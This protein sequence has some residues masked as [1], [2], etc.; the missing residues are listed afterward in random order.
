MGIQTF[1]E[2]LFDAWQTRKGLL[3]LDAQ[4][5]TVLKAQ[6]PVLHTAILTMRQEGVQITGQ[7]LMDAAGVVEAFLAQVFAIEADV[8]KQQLDSQNLHPIIHFKKHFVLKEAKRLLRRSA[9]LPDFKHLDAWLK[10]QLPKDASGDLEWHVATFAGHCLSEP[11]VHEKAI[12]QLIAWCAHGLETPEAK[13]QVATWVS[14]QTPQILQKDH[15]VESHM[16]DGVHSAT[17]KR[18]HRR[19]GFDLQDSGFSPRASLD[20]AHYC[21]YCH[22]KGT[23]FCRSGFPEKPKDKASP[24]K[25]NEAGL[26]LTGCPLDQKISEMH[27]LKALGHS[28]APLAIVMVD[29]PMCPAT[30]HRIC[31]DCMKSCIYQKQTPVNTPEVESRVLKDVLDLPWGVEVYDLLTK[32]NPLRAQQYLPE[33]P[34][35]KR[36]LVMG[37]GPAGFTLMHHLSM[38][39]IDVVGMDGMPLSAMPVS[40]S[41]PIKNKSVLYGALSERKPLGFGGVAEYG[42]TTR[43]DKNHLHLLYLTLMRRSSVH[44]IGSV[45]FGGTLHVEDVWR[46]GFDHL[47]LATGAGLPNALDIPGSLAPGMR[48]ASDFLM[49]LHLSDATHVEGQSLLDVSLPGLVI[50]GGL[51]AVDAATELQAYYLKQIESFVDR[52]EGLLSAFSE[53]ALLASFPDAQ[54]VRVEQWLEHG[55]ELKAAR[56]QS[57]SVFDPAPLLKKWGGV[58][59]VYRKAMQASPAYRLN[60]EELQHALDQ[61]IQWMDEASPLRIQTDAKGHVAALVVEHRGEQCVLPAKSILVATGLRLNVAYEFEHRGT[62]DRADTFAYQ[63]FDDAGV[64]WDGGQKHHCKDP[65]SPWSSYP[66]QK[67]SLLGDLHPMFQGSVV[68]AMASAKRIYPRIVE[69]LKSQALP[70][71]QV[72]QD[73]WLAQI[74][75]L[76]HSYVKANVHLFDQWHALVVQSSLAVHH[77]KLGHLFRL[78]VGK[79]G[80]GVTLSPTRIDHDAGTLTFVF[81]ASKHLHLKELLVGDALGVMGPSGIA[82]KPPKQTTHHL[83]ITDQVMWPLVLAQVRL[84]VPLG[85]TV[86]V[87][88]HTSEPTDPI[89][90]LLQ[91]AGAHVHQVVGQSFIKTEAWANAWQGE[92]CQSVSL[93]VTPDHLAKHRCLYGK[94]MPWLSHDAHWDVAAWGPFQCLL[95]G[96]CAQCLQWQIDPKTAKR[97]KAVYS[98]SW[99]YQS[100]DMIDLEHL[101]SRQYVGQVEKVLEALE[102]SLDR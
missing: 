24:L 19:D 48:S 56:E 70:S 53:E 88:L 58:K 23:D 32:W 41:R 35:N 20:H 78:D 66:E 1:D 64:P 14:F 67:V 38:A 98:C 15:L 5:L 74:K 63:V 13:A 26:M 87:I 72:I 47:A 65:L 45:R 55:R 71:H 39:G 51:T 79:I 81:D 62:F 57:K 22:D 99:P 44:M 25:E 76:G 31:N 96:V 49:A 34:S 84:L 94:A 27:A 46:L 50:G 2:A 43:W 61:G 101:Q 3:A 73:D 60:H 82:F 59:I 91:E 54:R 83:C 68:K 75:T 9:A 16:H 42:I 21:V 17:P 37:L 93:Y 100:M 29:N 85:I 6:H 92:R 11:A 30:G 33:A 4:F 18:Y 90:A 89:K 80:Q 102:C 10:A 28:I 95:K 77:A 86:G 8:Q 36:V 97:T 12:S 7:V 52:F 40:W 69:A